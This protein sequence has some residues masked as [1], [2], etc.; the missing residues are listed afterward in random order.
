M[1]KTWNTVDEIL[2]RMRV[3]AV[4]GLSGRPDRPSYQ[5]A[6]YLQAQ[7]LR[8]IPVNPTIADV[9]GEKAYPSLRDVPVS[10]DVVDV[11]RRP[12]EIEPIVDDAIT[13]GAP[14]LWLQLGVVNDAAA[15]QAEAAGMTVVMDRCLKVE[16]QKSRERM[17]HW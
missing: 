8:I 7:G 1:N 5:V 16:H 2:K 11:F 14:V 6:S 12:D 4:V 10:I 9:L 17:R 13:V 3:V 15:R